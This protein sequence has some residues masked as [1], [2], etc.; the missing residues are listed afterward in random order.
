MVCTCYDPEARDK[1]SEPENRK[2]HRAFCSI[3]NEVCTVDIWVPCEVWRA[4]LHK[5]HWNGYVCVRCFTR[6][7]DERGVDWSKDIQF[8]PQSRVA[9]DREVAVQDF[10]NKI[11]HGD[12]KHRAWLIEAAQCFA[13]GKP[14]PFPPS[15]P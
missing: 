6:N 3:C 15:P 14:L 2:A 1:S 4:A 12:E 5:D 10:A 13:A 11:L 7:A 9:F 8:F